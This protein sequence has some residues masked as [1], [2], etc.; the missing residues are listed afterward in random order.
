MK[1]PKQPV[2]IRDEP[3]ELPIPF[4]WQP[5]IEFLNQGQQWPLWREPFLVTINRDLLRP[6]KSLAIRGETKAIK[7]ILTT[8]ERAIPQA[9]NA[10]RVFL[11]W[12]L[13][14]EPL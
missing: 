7:K 14:F 2:I 13:H 1:V 9:G 11:D 12:N 3:I 8:D 10:S 5:M 4:A 6:A